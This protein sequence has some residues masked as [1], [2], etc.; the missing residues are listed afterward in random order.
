MREMKIKFFAIVIIGLFAIVIGTKKLIHKHEQQVLYKISDYAPEWININYNENNDT[1]PHHLLSN[2]EEYRLNKA[3]NIYEFRDILFEI[4]IN[5]ANKCGYEHFEQLRLM[6][7]Y[8]NRPNSKDEV[9]QKRLM[10]Y[11]CRKEFEVGLRA[12]FELGQWKPGMNSNDVK[13]IYEYC[14]GNSSV[15]PKT[16]WLPF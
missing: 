9:E 16:P 11:E 7:F 1:R 13:M 8:Q 6:K 14:Y 5:H 15:K 12:A 2:E 4:N 3:K 10:A